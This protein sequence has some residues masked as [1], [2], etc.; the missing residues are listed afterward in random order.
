MDGSI[1]FIPY[2]PVEKHGVTGDRRSAA[3]VAV[4][5]TLDWL[6]WPNY[7]SP[8][9]FGVLL[10][11][12]KGGYW[13]IGPASPVPGQQTFLAGSPVL[14]T[15]WET[16]SGRLELADIMP[17]PQDDRGPGQAGR[18][19]V[20][21]RLRCLKGSFKAVVECNPRLNFQEAAQVSAVEGGYRFDLPG[22]FLGL[23]SS[24]PLEA[25]PG[26]VAASFEVKEGE[27]AWFVL[28]LDEDATRWNLAAARAAF[29]STLDYWNNWVEHLVYTGPHR[30]K[31]CHSAMILHLLSYAPT[32]SAVAAP[33]TSLPERTGGDRNYDYRFAWV[34]DASLSLSILSLLGKTWAAWR[35]LEWLSSLESASEEPIQVVYSVDGG[36]CLDERELENVEGYCRSRPVR[37]GNRA[38]KQ[39]QLD[40]F[41]YLVECGLTYVEQGC[42]WE[43]KYWDMTKKVVEYVLENWQKPDN[44]I[45][46]LPHA[47]HYVSSK[48]M[49]WVAL[50]RAVKLARQTG[51]GDEVDSWQEVADRIHA[52]VMERGWSEKLQAFRQRY[53]HDSL[54]ASCLLISVME[55][56]PGDHPRMVATLERLE[57][58]LTLDGFIY[59]FDPAQTPGHPALP[60]GEFEGAFLPCTFWLANAYARAGQLE[61]C[62]TLL[63]KSEK[64]AGDLGLFAEEID[65]RN[66]AFLGNSPMIF[67]HAEYL[68]ALLTLANQRTLDRVRMSVGQTIQRVGKLVGLDEPARHE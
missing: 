39:R 61:K 23:W 5:G 68:G 62:E 44:G 40:S 12:A 10:D 14:L 59:R 65:P 15:T 42:T 20:I 54:D 9:L 25:K 26:Q 8:P 35:Y 4:D 24:V 27:E 28:A 17:W 6:C 57:A 51:H 7:D 60:V 32:G 63:A 29:D 11:A 67:S 18:R 16:A 47:D 36:T 41:G 2:P 19:A 38:Y 46:E 13:R 33:T 66:G 37:V 22:H 64:L 49:S 58:S 31:V 34:R 30:K 53:D 45:W 1:P 50:D 43:P 3:L 56:L 55:F 48:V 52:E 21:R